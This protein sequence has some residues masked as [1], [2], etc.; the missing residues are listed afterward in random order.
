[1]KSKQPDNTT[2]SLLQLY[3]IIPAEAIKTGQISIFLDTPSEIEK[4]VERYNDIMFEHRRLMKRITM[5]KD[6]IMYITLII[7]LG[8]LV[9]D[10]AICILGLSNLGIQDYQICIF[11]MVAVAIVYIYF[12]I[13]KGNVR[14]VALAS[15]ALSM[16]YITVLPVCVLN[17]VFYVIYQHFDT[18][19]KKEREYPLFAPIIIHYE[20]FNTPK[21]KQ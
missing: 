2:P 19:L 8:L 16:I 14:A 20:R 3:E 12:G 13:L 5:L 1:M 18:P 11:I 6:I 4:A 17:L 10:K 9:Y 21:K 15:V 7:W